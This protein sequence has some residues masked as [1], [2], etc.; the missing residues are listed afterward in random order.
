M[1]RNVIY[2]ASPETVNNMRRYRDHIHQA[3][4]PY[5]NRRVRV[6]TID[7][8]VYEG[9]LVYLDG[10]LLHLQTTHPHHAV[11]SINRSFFNPYSSA[12]LPLVLYELLVITLLY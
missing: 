4:A 2:Q 5:L 6:Q 8:H 10:G 12:I 7:G 9:I 3:A 1:D 11:H